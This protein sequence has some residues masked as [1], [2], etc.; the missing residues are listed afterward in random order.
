MSNVLI[1]FLGTGPNEKGIDNIRQYREATYRF[2]DGASIKRSFF[3]AVM[4]DYY[5][6]DRIIL[7]GT[8]HSMWEEAYRQFSA[9]ESFD[10]DYYVELADFCEKSTHKTAFG[11]FPDLDRLKRSIGNNSHILLVHYGISE[12]EILQ[13]QQ[14]VLG[15]ESLLENGDNLYVDITHSFRSLPLF[16]LNSLIYIQQVSPKHISIKRIAYGMLD[17]IRELGYA[18]VVE[19]NSILDTT[20]WIIGAYSFREFGNAYRIAG[21]VK[22]SDPD[23]SNRL[24]RFSDAMNINYL[25]ALKKQSDIQS[26]RNKQYESVLASMVLTPIVDDFCRTFGNPSTEPTYRFQI[27]LAN[28]HF[29]HHNYASAA[30]CAAEAIVTYICTLSKLNSEDMQ[31]REMSKQYL[32]GIVPPSGITN[33]ERCRLLKNPYKKL[34]RIRNTSAHSIENE[35]SVKDTIQSLGSILSEVTHIILD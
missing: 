13:N 8:V 11:A 4:N 27:N 15:L 1:S 10:M 16:L 22:E 7:I 23:L 24:I 14:I 19:L 33:P 31:C 18:P 21:Q 35:R 26:L 32:R 20:D 12:E 9:D 28:W 3:A 2:N 5:D 30:I 6:I 17:A 25:S 34:V 29:K